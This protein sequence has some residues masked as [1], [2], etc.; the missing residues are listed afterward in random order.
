M[1]LSTASTVLTSIGV[2]TLV[3]ILLVW[4]LL[5]AKSKL[6]PSG[7]VKLNINGEISEVE[8]GST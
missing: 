4:I 8:S 3:T 6:S 1:F 2:F 7:P 5:F